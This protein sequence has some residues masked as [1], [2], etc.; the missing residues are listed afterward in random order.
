MKKYLVTLIAF[1]FLFTACENKVKEEST[2]EEQVVL[3]E[4]I[5][6][7]SISNFEIKAEELVGKQIILSGTV[8]H[9]CQHGGQKMFIIETESEGRIKIIPDENIAAFNTELEGQNIKLVGIVEEQRIDE[10]YL[11]EWEEEILADVD[12]GDD[13]GEG[14][15]LGG[16][17]EKGG[18]DADKS[19]ELEKVNNLRQQIAESGKDHLSFFSVLCTEYEVV[20]T[21]DSEPV[22]E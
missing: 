20:E 11:R 22:Q 5:V 18:E 21:D 6:P 3:I 12:M 8:D 13:K 7:V 14:K 2:T 16:N 10:E 9:I 1:V 4:E 15:H 19:E 17:M